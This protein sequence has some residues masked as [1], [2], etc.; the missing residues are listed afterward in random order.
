[1]IEITKEMLE[2]TYNRQQN[3]LKSVSV[4]TI[5][6]WIIWF[7]YRRLYD[8]IPEG[9]L[10]F[11]MLLR[12]LIFFLP[13]IFAAVAKKKIMPAGNGKIVME[14]FKDIQYDFLSDRA[15][16]R[17]Y[18]AMGMANNAA[19]K[20]KLQLLLADVFMFRGQYSDAVS[21][22]NSVDRSRFM[23]YPEIALTYFGDTVSVYNEMGDNNSVIAAYRDAEPFI[24]ECAGRN[25]VCC[26][27]ALEICIIAEKAMGNY[28]RALD[29]RLMKNEFENKLNKD[30]ID[31]NL[32]Y[33]KTSINTFN[34]GLVFFGTAEL[35]YL[36]GDFS[37]AAKYLDIGGPMLAMSNVQTEKAN[38]LSAKI[39]EALGSPHN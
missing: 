17:L 29:M 27:S 28:R 10:L 37:N 38:E 34:K 25:Y 35:F 9:L 26:Q 11:A 19:D 36:C 18:Q 39:R 6:C 12:I 21:M 31:R 30:L 1:M 8:F 4:V 24:K 15:V 14:T 22:L 16:N 2:K 3:F 23:H 32:S 7:C 33:N 13:L 20:I 5:V